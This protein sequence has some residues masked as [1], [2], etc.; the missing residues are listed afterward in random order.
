M[1]TTITKTK[2]NFSSHPQQTSKKGRRTL[3][4]LCSERMETTQ[5]KN[6]IYLY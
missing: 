5:G 3:R 4:T 1:K 6:I 2:Q